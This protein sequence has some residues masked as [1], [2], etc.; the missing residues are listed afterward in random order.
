MSAA[1]G[2]LSVATRSARCLRSSALAHT[3]RLSVERAQSSARAFHLASRASSSSQYAQSQLKPRR[4]H[5]RGYAGGPGLQGP[6]E[7]HKDKAAIGVRIPV[8]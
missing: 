2:A 3:S 6:S 7:G 1:F 4:G 5:S 8:S